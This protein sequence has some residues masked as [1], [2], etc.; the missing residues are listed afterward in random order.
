MDDLFSDAAGCD[1]T[2]LEE[3]RAKGKTST[4]AQARAIAHGLAYDPH[5]EGKLKLTPAG[6]EK[7]R[8]AREL[9]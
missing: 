9:V 1:V 3:I 8:A 5:V 7:L 4:K 6:R 2:A